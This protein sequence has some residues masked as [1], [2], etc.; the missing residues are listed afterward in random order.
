VVQAIIDKQRKFFQTNATRTLDFRI[1]QLKLLK[2]MLKSNEDD[3]LDALKIDLGKSRFEGFVS[4]LAMV[5]QEIDLAKRRLRRWMKPRCVPSTL[6]TFP[7]KSKIYPEP[8]GV[9]LIVSPWNYPVQLTFV[10]LVSA[11]AA[12]NT[13]FVKL[14]HACEHTTQLLKKIIMETFPSDYIHATEQ[15]QDGNQLLIDH[16]FDYV[17]FT[18]SPTIGKLVMAHCAKHL[19]PLTLELGGK[20]PCIVDETADLKIAA[21]RIVFG[22]VINSGQTCVAPDYVLAQRSIRDRLVKEITIAYQTFFPR[23]VESEDHPS[24]INDHHWNRLVGLLGGQKNIVAMEGSCECRKRPLTLIFDPPLDSPLMKE[25]IF[26]PLL[27]IL[28]FDSLEEAFSII[29]SIEKPLAL[30]CFSKRRTTIDTVISSLSFGGGAINDTVL[31]VANHHL[32]FGG[33]G[34]S[35]MGA[36]HGKKGFDTFTHLKAIL[37]SVNW[38]DPGFKYPPFNQKMLTF[39]KRIVK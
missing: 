7:G 6:F 31:H 27:P 9:V 22:K 16:R 35:G 11:I 23:G 34:N 28:V 39:L 18:G 5:Y 20:S 38:I 24:I 15:H 33:I 26:G 1:Q 8:Y 29:R 14:S 2:K 4:E 25:E 36:Y 30:Y 37:H 32:P 10:P 12:G 21:K 3:L 13:A 17:F 19:T